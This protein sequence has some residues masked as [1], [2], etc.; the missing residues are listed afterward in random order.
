VISI[1][2]KS[3]YVLYWDSELILSPI[4]MYLPQQPYRCYSF[5]CRYTWG[6]WR[7]SSIIHR[8]LWSKPTTTVVMCWTVVSSLF[9]H[10]V[11]GYFIWTTCF[12]IDKLFCWDYDC[13]IMFFVVRCNS[14]YQVHVMGY[15]PYVGW[16][17]NSR[18]TVEK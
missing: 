10:F 11:Y 8:V 1:L 14:D 7:F 13:I 16:A 15:V 6:G 17:T 18:A 5:G 3:R 12:T 9:V 2:L 4:R